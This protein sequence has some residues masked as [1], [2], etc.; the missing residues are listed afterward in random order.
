MKSRMSR[1]ISYSSVV[2]TIALV[3]AMSGGAMAAGHYLIDSTKQI[4][5]KVLKKLRGNTGPR[6]ATGSQGATGTTGPEGPAG[7]PGSPGSPGTEGPPEPGAKLATL[8]PTS[9][10]SE[11]QALFSYG[12]S[13]VGVG[14]TTGSA[15]KAMI[16]VRGGNIAW[17]GTSTKQEGSK[18]AEARPYFSA[19]DPGETYDLIEAVEITESHSA[20]YSSEQL[21]VEAKNANFE[22]DL[23]ADVTSGIALGQLHCTF[24]AIY[25]PLSS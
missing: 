15:D 21:T 1:R 16:Y 5:P 25:Y 18:P 12:G 4:S 11:P 2:A 13:T 10:T 9:A 14:C 19:L 22:V 7:T 6:G 20:A 17:S 3:F 24:K 8:S 23:D